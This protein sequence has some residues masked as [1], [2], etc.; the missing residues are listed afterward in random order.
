MC[1]AADVG[2]AAVHVGGAPARLADEEQAGGHVPGVESELPE[3]VQP[4]AGDV[5]EVDGGRA[6]RRTPCENIATWWKKWT[7]TFSWRL[8]EGKPVASSADLDFGRFADVDAAAVQVGAAAAL[9]G[10]HLLAHGVVDDA[11]DQSRRPVPAPA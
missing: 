3:A 7:L 4:S 5:G 1:V 2:W 8:R 11:G 9:G 6:A 10:E